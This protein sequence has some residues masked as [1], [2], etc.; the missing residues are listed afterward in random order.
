MG[1]QKELMNMFEYSENPDLIHVFFRH[2]PLNILKP[3]Q[4]LGCRVGSVEAAL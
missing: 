2:V 3:T 1:N 4:P